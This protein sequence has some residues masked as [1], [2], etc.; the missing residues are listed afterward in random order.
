MVWVLGLAVGLPALVVG[1]VTVAASALAVAV[2]APWLG[3]PGCRTGTA[4]LPGGAVGGGR[5]DFFE[6][7]GVTGSPTG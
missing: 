1:E 3:L 2:L 6:F 4:V 7:R 5:A